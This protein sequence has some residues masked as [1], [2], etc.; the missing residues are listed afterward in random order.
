MFKKMCL[1][2]ICLWANMASADICANGH[3][4]LIIGNDGVS[5]YCLSPLGMNW[6][7]AFAWCDAAGGKLLN[8]STECDKVT[9]TQPTWC[10]NLEGKIRDYIWTAN[11]SAGG[12]PYFFYAPNRVLADAWSKT[13]SQPKAL[14]T[15]N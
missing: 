4:T 13:N 14:C 11:I 1:M 10:A 5:K 6:W 3:G 8:L 15:L 7:S 2:G 9:P 12:N